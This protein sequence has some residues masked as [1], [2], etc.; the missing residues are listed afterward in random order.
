[1][2][3]GKDI[4]ILEFINKFY[5]AKSNYIFRACFPNSKSNSYCFDRIK[6]LV[7]IGLLRRLN[8]DNTKIITLSKRGGTFLASV[9]KYV[10]TPE[11]FDSKILFHNEFV[12]NIAIFYINKGFIVDTESEISAIGMDDGFLPDFRIHNENTLYH[13]EIELS[14]KAE[15]RIEKKLFHVASFNSCYGTNRE[16]ESAVEEKLI[17]ITNNKVVHNKIDRIANSKNLTKYVEI[18]R[19]NNFKDISEKKQLQLLEVINA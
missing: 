7:D 17:Y 15:H 19:I 8:V 1:M 5:F 11:S 6:H 10:K 2:I 18:I 16:E 12:A 13:F 14:L 3:T 9:G 4:E